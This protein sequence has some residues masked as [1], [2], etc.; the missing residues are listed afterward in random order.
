MPITIGYDVPFTTQGPIAYDSGR[1]RFLQ[2]Q[3]RF[4]E[5]TR[6]FD[7]YQAFR[8]QSLA[9]QAR[10]A[11]NR[12]A[13][14][15]DAMRAQQGLSY[16]QLGEQ[17]RQF[18]ARLQQSGFLATEELAQRQQREQEL[19]QYRNDA[20]NQQ[21]RQSLRGDL[22]GMLKQKQQQQFALG[23]SDWEKIQSFDGYRSPEAKQ[24]AEAQWMSKYGESFG[25]A[26]P[27]STPWQDQGLQ[28]YD[29]VHNTL[30]TAFGDQD[31]PPGVVDWYYE[32]T[33]DGYK[34][35][36]RP[37]AAGAAYETIRREQA[38]IERQRLSGEATLAKETSKQQ[39]TQEQKEY[40][41]SLSLQQDY[42]KGLRDWMKDRAS[43]LQKER[44][45]WR[46]GQAA[47]LGEDDKSNVATLSPDGETGWADLEQQWQ[48]DYSRLNP[49]PTPDMYGIS[50]GQSPETGDVAQGTL[51]N[52]FRVQTFD[53]ARQLPPGS[54]FIGPDGATRQVNG[55]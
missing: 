40:E 28:Q 2:E 16:D 54:Y 50:S 19:S 48:Q 31:L 49:Q 53:Q 45:N 24:Q 13:Y 22:A 47:T 43:Y 18:D 9:E 10:Q 51:A 39:S 44:A 32:K 15:Y 35:R 8:E 46:T 12:Q 29:Q 52:P 17:S 42:Q 26:P 20:L 34:E 25:G 4:N 23:V 38:A 7:E 6:Q 14:S 55:Q 21:E 30:K 5:S 33:D 27:T 3:D 41:R 36:E 37:T 11:D 1:G